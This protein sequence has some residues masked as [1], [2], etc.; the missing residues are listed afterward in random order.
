VA[1][2]RGQGAVPVS[3]GWQLACALGAIV[4]MLAFLA[5]MWLVIGR[6]L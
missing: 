5:G 6:K 1:L 2:G 3:Q 4:L